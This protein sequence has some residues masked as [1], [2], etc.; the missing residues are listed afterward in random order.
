MTNRVLV[1]PVPTA[2]QPQGTW[3]RQPCCPPPPRKDTNIPTA[4]TDPTITGSPPRN[5][6]P[7]V[8]GVGGH[9]PTSKAQGNNHERESASVLPFA[10]HS[11]QEAVPQQL[12][13]FRPTSKAQGNNHER[14][15]ASA[16]PLICHSLQDAKSEH[17]KMTNVSEDF[18]FNHARPTQNARDPSFDRLGL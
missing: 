15:G 6:R 4:T 2:H 16:L 14:Q 9:P 3:A 17:Q 1:G 10:C 12:L 18:F 13:I 5:A 7:E 11:L 8:P